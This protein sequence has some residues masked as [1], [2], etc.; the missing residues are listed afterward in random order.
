MS[1]KLKHETIHSS[2]RREH[3]FFPSVWYLTLA[4]TSSRDRT[5]S[6]PLF[7]QRSELPLFLHYFR[8]GL[9]PQLAE[10]PPQ[11]KMFHAK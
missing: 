8:S 10:Y 4:G 9:F 7:W 5:I 3:E 2:N 6:L 1:S 11:M